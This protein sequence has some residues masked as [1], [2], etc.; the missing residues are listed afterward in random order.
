MGTPNDW[1]HLSLVSP[2]PPAVRSVPLAPPPACSWS[3][4]P[5]SVNPASLKNETAR[6]ALT[7]AVRVRVGP[8][9]GYPGRGGA[10]LWGSPPWGP[11]LERR[12]H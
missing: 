11:K 9:K 12:A 6:F 8:P 1:S 10:F 2:C 4:S 7:K 3:F 5:R